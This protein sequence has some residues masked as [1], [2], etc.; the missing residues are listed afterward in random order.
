MG[1][2]CTSTIVL[3]T[4]EESLRSG[5][6]QKMVSA[7]VRIK[8]E[9]GYQ[10]ENTSDLSAQGQII[11]KFSGYFGGEERAKHHYDEIDLRTPK[12]EIPKP[13]VSDWITNAQIEEIVEHVRKLDKEDKTRARK[14]DE[15]RSTPPKR[16]GWLW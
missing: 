3:L 1:A 7:V 6:N 16:K 9:G 8:I 4:D 13:E 12:P 5:K 2:H 10:I 14:L 11:L 15:P